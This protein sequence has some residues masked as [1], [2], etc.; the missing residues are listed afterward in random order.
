LIALLLGACN[1]SSTGGR[2]ENITTPTT[3]TGGRPSVQIL[4]PQNGDEAVV[5]EDVLVSV[6]ATDAAGVT[7]VQLLANGQIVKTVSSESP[8]GDQVFSALLDYTPTQEGDVT[9]QVIAYRAAIASDPASVQITVREEEAQV[10]ATSLPQ[11]NVPVIDP[12][13]PTCRALTNT[14]LRLRSG[15]GTNYNQIGLL[16]AGS[17]VPIIGRIGSN[18]WWQ[19]RV[20]VTIGWISAAYTNV[21]GICSGVPV[22]QPPP[23]P[24][25]L[26]TNTVIPTNTLTL[27]APPATATPTPGPADLLVTNIVGSTTLALGEGSSPVTSSYTVT[28][29][30][31]GSSPTGQFNNT[32]SVSPGGAT[33]PLGVVASLA[34]HESIVLNVSL[35]F[36][37]AGTYSIQARVDSD[38]QVTELS[39]V[40]NVGNLDVTVNPPPGP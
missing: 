15:P 13:D 24:T 2:E 11:A 25:P 14:A 37:T 12:N 32:I 16:N 10:T 31:N 17:V 36:G 18:E 23:T 5:D 22:V 21:Y 28:I 9:L 35:T 38:N 19:V 8:T 27:T 40:N 20:N 30:N 7:R 4:A 6:T 3:V 33:T 34:P 39:E 1:L 29:T 26:V